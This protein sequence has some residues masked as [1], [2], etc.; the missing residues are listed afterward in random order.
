MILVMK[1]LRD[2]VTVDV[3]SHDDAFKDV[4]IQ[5]QSVICKNERIPLICTSKNDISPQNDKD[6]S[7]SRDSEDMLLDTTV[8]GSKAMSNVQQRVTEYEFNMTRDLSYLPDFQEEKMKN[9]SCD[10]LGSS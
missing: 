1:I 6:Q 5:G 2:F 4:K 10:S 3:D 7:T 8:V 9:S